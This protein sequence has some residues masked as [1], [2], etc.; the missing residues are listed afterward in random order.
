MPPLE[1]FANNASTSLAGAGQPW[2]SA[3]AAGT[4]ETWQVTNSGSPLPQPVNL[5][6]QYRAAISPPAV[7]PTLP[8]TNPEIVL[9]TSVPDST[10]VVVTRGAESSTVKT[11]SSGDLL[12][13]I[14]TLGNLA[15]FPFT[16][17][18]SSSSS[19]AIAAKAAL[20]SSA[21]LT[22]A[23]I[24]PTIVGNNTKGRV[25]FTTGA[26]VVVGVGLVTVTLPTTYPTIP[27]VDLIP[28]N[29][30]TAFAQP[31]PFNITTSTFD[32]GLRNPLFQIPIDLYY[33]VIG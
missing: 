18:L 32:I 10:H 20:G 22:F 26:D 25:T 3:P 13:C 31:V 23:G 15:I 17:L 28:N 29:S 21:F 16:Q 9:V 19:A 24:V 8:D 27:T 2:A 11:H 12:I 7:A 30:D 5:T 14:V 6:S 1:L 33:Q 4:S